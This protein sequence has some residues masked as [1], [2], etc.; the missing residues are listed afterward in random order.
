M[1]WH[2]PNLQHTKHMLLCTGSTQSM[3]VRGSV[4]PWGDRRE[5][6]GTCTRDVERPPLLDAAYI[7][8]KHFKNPHP[9]LHWSKVPDHSQPLWF[10]TSLPEATPQSTSCTPWSPAFPGAS[11][12][13][14]TATPEA[15]TGTFRKSPWTT[16][17]LPAQSQLDSLAAQQSLGLRQGHWHGTT[18]PVQ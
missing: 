13:D 10:A 4:G 7:W 15:L 14:H 3:S 8:I 18:V 11:P 16:G 6:A 9:R 17:V 2:K 1:V 12:P 5:R